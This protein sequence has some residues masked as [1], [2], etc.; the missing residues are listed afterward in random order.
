ML[1]GRVQLAR[2][3]YRKGKITLLSNLS[4]SKFFSLTMSKVTGSSRLS[5]ISPVSRRRVAKV[6]GGKHV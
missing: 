5:A 4:C 2:T 6:K 3:E 1:A